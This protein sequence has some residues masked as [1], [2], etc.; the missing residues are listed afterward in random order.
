MCVL[1]RP[2]VLPDSEPQLEIS[3]SF[4]SPYLQFSYLLYLFLLVLRLL[5][6][7]IALVVVEALH[8]IAT[9]IGGGVSVAKTHPWKCCN[10]AMNVISSNRVI[11]H[12]SH[13]KTGHK[14]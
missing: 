6:G 3:D 4:P 13:R 14:P 5:A 9:A 1:A 2:P 7:T 12:T 8:K 10:R 11:P